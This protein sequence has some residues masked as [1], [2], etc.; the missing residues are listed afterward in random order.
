MIPVPDR[1]V[2]KL[3]I[4]I[5][6]LL[7]LALLIQ[8]RNHWKAKTGHYAELLAAERGAHAGTAANYRAAAELARQADRENAARV[9]FEQTAI[10]ERSAHDFESRIVAA[11]AADLRLRLR[12]EAAAADPGGIRGAPVPVVPAAAG[13]PAQATG[14]DGFPRSDRLIATEQAIQ[15]DELIKWV[16]AQAKVAPDRQ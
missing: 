6:S 2:L 13:R 11:R 14:E 3:V 15:L 8:D 4:G 9:K 10:N 1:L 5:G 16:T 12:P 7:M